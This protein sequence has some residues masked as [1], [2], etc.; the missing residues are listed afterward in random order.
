MSRALY[1]EQMNKFYPSNS[2]VEPILTCGG[3][4]TRSIP[5]LGE[6]RYA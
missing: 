4:I 6:V 3:G 2:L 1:A 5:A